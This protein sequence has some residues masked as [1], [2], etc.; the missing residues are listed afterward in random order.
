MV[1]WVGP[2]E[3][4]KLGT[5]ATCLS[6]LITWSAAPKSWGWAGL[7]AQASPTSPPFRPQ[8]RPENM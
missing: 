5:R 7:E 2:L 8:N 1:F 3:H 6:Q 4:T